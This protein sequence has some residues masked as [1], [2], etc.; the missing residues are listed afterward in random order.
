MS[1]PLG[2]CRA[3][4]RRFCL[5]RVRGMVPPH[6]LSGMSHMGA[7]TATGYRWV[8]SVRAAQG[9]SR[10][11]LGDSPRGRG[12]E[13]LDGVGRTRRAGRFCVHIVAALAHS[14]PSRALALPAVGKLTLYAVTGTRDLLMRHR[15]DGSSK[16]LLM[17][18]RSIWAAYSA[19]RQSADSESFTFMAISRKTLTAQDYR[20]RI[21]ALQGKPL[22]N[23][24]GNPVGFPLCENRYASPQTVTEWLSARFFI[25]EPVPEGQHAPHVVGR[26]P[27]SVF[28][29]RRLTAVTAVTSSGPTASPA[30]GSSAPAPP[31]PAAS[32]P[33][34]TPPRRTRRCR[35]AS[36]CRVGWA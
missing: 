20:L 34:L 7:V 10:A 9:L 30:A 28:H 3:R 23:G 1:V 18:Y 12:E 11:I 5:G 25:I 4:R 32:R 36:G 13:W 29:R 31:S 22:R 8:C 24:G 33:E 35:R 2:A 6:P 15:A 17:R 21:G 14:L 19:G 26:E 27:P 16:W